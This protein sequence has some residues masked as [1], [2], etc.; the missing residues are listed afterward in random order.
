MTEDP[1]VAVAAQTSGPTLHGCSAAA[2]AL[3]WTIRSGHVIAIPE[4]GSVAH[5]KE[6]RGRALTETDTAGAS[7][8][9]CGT[10]ASPLV[11]PR[12]VSP[13]MRGLHYSALA[14]EAHCFLLSTGPKTFC[15]STL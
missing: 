15:T 13:F 5:V 8:A 12:F 1:A 14:A 2:V 6:E 7:N 9:G 3:A 10:S 11:A 4:S